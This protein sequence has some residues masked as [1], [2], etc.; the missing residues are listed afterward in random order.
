MLNI[1]I[2]IRQ[3]MIAAQVNPEAFE[4]IKNFRETVGVRRSLSRI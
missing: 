2:Y 1:P 4:T 3:A